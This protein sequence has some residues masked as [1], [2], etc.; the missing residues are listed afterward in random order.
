MKFKKLLSAMFVAG[1]A[2]SAHAGVVF[3][4]GFDSVAGLA[5]AGWAQVNASVIAGNPY[6]QGNPGVFSS[7]SGAA[8]SYVGANFL[9]G[10]Q[11]ISNWLMTPTLTMSGGAMVDFVVR[12]AGGGFLDTVQVWLSSNGASTN[13]ADFTTLLG[14]YS[15]STD[16]GW[17]AQNYRMNLVGQGRIGFRYFVADATIDGNYIGID[18][19][20]V[21]PEPASLAL[22]AL[23]LV[24]AAAVR[25]RA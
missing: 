1:A 5:G 18:N 15:S 19:L 16:Q 4:E 25:R 9:S 2:C 22:V 12:T 6:F 17:I 7:F 10:S 24:G 14:T 21:V 13:V 3:S 23:A 11:T 8:N 20:A